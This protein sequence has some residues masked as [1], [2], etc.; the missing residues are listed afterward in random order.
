V[1]T[2]SQQF[3]SRFPSVGKQIPGVQV[4]PLIPNTFPA[5]FRSWANKS[6]ESSCV[7]LF[8]TIF[9]PIFFRG[10]T[11]LRSPGVSTDS[12]QFSC[13]FCFVGKQNLRGV[14]LC[15]LIPHKFPADFRSWANK[16]Q[17]SRCVHRCPTIF[18]PI[19]VRGQTNPRSPGVSIDSPQ[20]FSRFP[21]VGKQNPSGFPVRP[22]I[23]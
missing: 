11:N 1:S 17:E 19:S 10:Q 2:D 3:S 7:L 14:H 16:S 5:D 22:Q 13:R 18:Q 8:P 12:Q 6:Q 15:P 9:P 23:P 20:F 21:V 4:C